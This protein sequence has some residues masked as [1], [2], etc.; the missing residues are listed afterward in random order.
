DVLRRVGRVLFD[1]GR[2]A[3]LCRMI[4]T[5]V[6]SPRPRS[7]RGSTAGLRTWRPVE[8]L[9]GRIWCGLFE[10]GRGRPLPKRYAVLLR[11]QACHDGGSVGM[12]KRDARCDRRLDA[13]VYR[14]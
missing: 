12:L 11:L 5:R 9:V 4:E 14:L 13:L 8:A 3:G 2:K 10:V 7:R 1:C 6:V